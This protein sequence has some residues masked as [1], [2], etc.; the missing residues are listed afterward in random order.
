MLMKIFEC[1]WKKLKDRMMR[2]EGGC[3]K[4]SWKVRLM[5]GRRG[6]KGMRDR[7]IELRK[8]VKG[9]FG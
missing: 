8:V 6:R 2:K 1:I 4:M 7:V 5:F 3:V 9:R